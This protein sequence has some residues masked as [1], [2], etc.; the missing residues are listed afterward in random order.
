MNEFIYQMQVHADDIDGFGIVH[1]ANFIKFME[2]ARTQWLFNLGFR[3]DQLMTDR[4]L[5]VI[6]KI[7]IEYIAPAK[8]YDELTIQTRIIQQRKV[9]KTYEQIIFSTQ[10]KNKIFCKAHIQVVC[11]NDKLRPRAIPL[12]IVE[13]CGYDKI[14]NAL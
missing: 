5:F 3:L 10:D 12:R 6:K 2:R 7:E 11:V 8:L 9:S 4:I 13:A 1:H 14:K